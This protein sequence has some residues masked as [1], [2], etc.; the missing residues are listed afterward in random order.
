MKR[1]TKFLI[2]HIWMILRGV[3]FCGDPGRVNVTV[4]RK[5]ERMM[6]TG[7][8]IVADIFCVRCGSIL[9][10]KYVRGSFP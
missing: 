8:H 9:G 5:E 10:W 1:V 2:Q 6:T 4:G 3:D 7:M